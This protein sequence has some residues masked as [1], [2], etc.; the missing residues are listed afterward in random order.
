MIN[1]VDGTQTNG[2]LTKFSDCQSPNI[3][4]SKQNM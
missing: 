1:G 3:K 2:T 4:S